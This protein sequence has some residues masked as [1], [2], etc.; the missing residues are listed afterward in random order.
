MSRRRADT[1]GSGSPDGNKGFPAG[2][3]SSVLLA[4]GAPHNTPLPPTCPPD[5]RCSPSWQEWPGGLWVSLLDIP[6]T[7]FQK[8]LDSVG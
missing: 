4:L 1:E 2:A 3:G 6:R 5:G 7:H 8:L